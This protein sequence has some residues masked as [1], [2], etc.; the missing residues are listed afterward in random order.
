M[1][2]PRRICCRDWRIAIL[3]VG[4]GL[5]RS[6]WRCEYPDAFFLLPDGVSYHGHAVSGG[7]KTGSGPLALKRE[8]R[9]LTGRSG[10]QAARR[11]NN[12]PAQLEELERE[13][14]FLSRRSG[15]PAR[16]CSRGRKKK[17]WRSIT[18]IAS[19]R[20]NSRAPVRGLS[21]ARLELRTAA[22]GRPSARRAQRERNRQLV[23]EK[24]AALR[25]R[26]AGARTIARAISKSCRRES[27]NSA[28]SMRALRADLAGLE[29]RR[30]SERTAQ[31][32]LEAQIRDVRRGATTSVREMERMGVE[33]AR[34][35]ADNIELDRRAGRV[36]RTKSLRLRT[37]WSRG[38]PSRKTACAPQS[39]GARRSALKTL[40][41]R[42]AGGAGDAAPQI[43]LE[44]VKRQAELKYLDETSRKELNAPLRRIGRRPKQ[45]VPRRRAAGRKPSSA[46]RKCAPRSKRWGR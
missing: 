8:L 7:K 14:A 15:T 42:S 25:V 10:G 38:W 12:P 37:K 36:D 44:L 11:W 24:E 41:D 17:R 35:L 32:R 31:A 29:E 22:P 27:H 28:K 33:R 13:I 16:R 39:A 4:C 45:T 43:E 40:R 34:L 19:W 5:R 30:R 1:R 6:G 46:I 18:S 26:R 3:V 20:K 9:E 2:Q 23:E 21:V